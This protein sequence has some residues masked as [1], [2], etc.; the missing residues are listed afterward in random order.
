MEIAMPTSPPTWPRPARGVPCNA[1]APHV[2]TGPSGEPR[3]QRL[4]SKPNSRLI[5]SPW[6]RSE[7]EKLHAR[8]VLSEHGARRAESAPLTCELAISIEIASPPMTLSLRRAPRRRRLAHAS[9][10]EPGRVR[11]AA[12]ADHVADICRPDVDD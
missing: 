8:V 5:V 3:H 9:G 4:R 10:P 12:G 6:P 7:L 2:G 11:R 1:P